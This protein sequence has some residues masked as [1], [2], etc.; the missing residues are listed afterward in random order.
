MLLAAGIGERMAP[1]SDLVA[2]PALEVL[3]APLLASSLAHLRRCGCAPVVVN[4]HRHAEAVE[5]AAA[6]TAGDLPLAFSRE[7]ELLGSA[8]GIAAARASFAPGPVLA[9]NADVW[10]EL[11]LEPLIERASAG[12][13]VLALMPHPDP[14]RWGAVKLDAGLVTAFLPPGGS[15]EGQPYLFTGFQIIG[16][17]VLAELPE[18]P[19]QIQTVWR[20]LLAAG[21]LHGAVVRGAWREAGSPAA[22]LDLVLDLLGGAVWTHAEAR[23]DPGARLERTA[24]GRGCHVSVGS[25]LV[26]C[27]LTAGA[28]V[29]PGCALQR[30][31]VAGPVVLAGAGKASDALFLPAG[32]YPLR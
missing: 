14:Q 30:C 28:T 10:A 9:A 25:H 4:L 19:A 6:V 13:I 21:R 7:P 20:L 18:P 27:V 23:V 24:V 8:G 11:D 12:T 16:E 5:A 3:G 15:A 2:K 29:G 1:L 26:D 32:R 17:Q 31:V 22:Y